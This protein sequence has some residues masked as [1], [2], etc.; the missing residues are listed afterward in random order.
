MSVSVKRIEGVESVT[1]SLE[2]GTADIRLRA[3]NKVTL[4]YIRRIIR[5]SG[6][7]TKG[8]EITA[9]GRLTGAGDTLALDLLNG[10]TLPVVMA[11]A[12]ASDRVVEIVAISHP[13][14]KRVERL[15]IRSI[16]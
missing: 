3:D 13:D 9:R 4:P 2:K 8:A 11:P 10:S 7:E 1:V 12:E 16:K 15:T 6:Y 5:G 14:D